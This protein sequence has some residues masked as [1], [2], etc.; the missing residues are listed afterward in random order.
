M[1]CT[2]EHANLTVRSIEETIRFITAAFPHFK[3]RGMGGSGKD[4]WVHIGTEDTYIALGEGKAEDRSGFYQET[5]VNHLGYV[6]DDA[7]AVKQRL[8]NAGF[9]EGFK[10]APH[11]HR[12]RV[13][14]FDPDGMEWEFVEY[15]SQDPAL[16]N[17]YSQ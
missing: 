14:F 6:V 13:Y 3:V 11:P 7:E 1:K 17:D 16:K 12:R 5:G 8:L 10:P 15:F 9:K 4:R 2:L